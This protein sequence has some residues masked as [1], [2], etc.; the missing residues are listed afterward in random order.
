MNRFSLDIG[1]RCTAE[2]N[3]ITEKNSGN[4]DT[5]K[6]KCSYLTDTII[7]CY[8]GNCGLCKIHSSVCEGAKNKW[9]RPY[10]NSKEY[11]AHHAFINPTQKDL[12]ILRACLNSRL[13]QKAVSKTFLNTNQNKCEG[14]NRGLVKGL[15]KHLT[16]AQNY[17]GRVHTCIHSMNNGPGQSLSQLCHTVGADLAPN[18]GVSKK[19]EHMDKVKSKD[20][21][22]KKSTEYMNTRVKHRQKLYNN[23]DTKKSEECYSKGQAN[24]GMISQRTSGETS[25]ETFRDEYTHNVR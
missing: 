17:P 18:S 16:F 22:R 11:Q 5:I 10:L 25:A 19:L 12:D 3:V 6:N 20:K 13:G 23:Y 9:K 2:F 15:P 21:I 7:Q 24:K 1:D 14:A 8:Q 4:M